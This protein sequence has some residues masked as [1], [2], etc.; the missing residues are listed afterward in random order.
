MQNIFKKDILF[1]HYGINVHDPNFIASLSPG[2]KE[3]I[4]G[5]AISTSNFGINKHISEERIKASVEFMKYVGLKEVQ[6][7]FLIKDHIMGTNMELYKDKNDEVCQFVPCEFIDKIDSL[8]FYDNDKRFFGSTEYLKNF[9]KYLLEYLFNDQPVDDVLQIL[10]DITKIYTFSI[11]PNDSIYGLIIFIVF[12]V[13]AIVITL[14]IVFVF[15]KKLEYRFKFLSKNFWIITTIGSLILLSAVLTLYGEVSNGKCHL[16]TFLINVGFI[17]S[18]CPSLHNLIA[19]FPKKNEISLKF[20]IN[21]Y[22]TLVVIMLITVCLNEV[23]SVA[24]FTIHEVNADI[25]P[26]SNTN[27][28]TSKHFNKCVMKNTFGKIMYY[29]IQIF[30]F[31]MI[32]ILLTLIFMEWNLKQ[33]ALDVKYLATALF[34]DILSLISLIIFS[35]T[36]IKNYIL[37]NVVLA[38]NIMFFAISNHIFIYLVRVLPIFRPDEEYEDSRKILGKIPISNHSK[39]KKY[40]GTNSSLNNKGLSS[41]NNKSSMAYYSN[42]ANSHYSNTGTSFYNNN[43]ATLSSSS[44]GNSCGSN[45]GTAASQKISYSST[46]K[47]SMPSSY[48]TINVDQSKSSKS[49]N[50]SLVTGST[51]MGGIVRK[52]M[53]YHNQTDIH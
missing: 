6:K 20:R 19:N 25:K 22:I 28:N 51:G 8:A 18:I 49:D 27:S 10:E 5:T 46:Y 53:D 36:E 2:W 16:R 4:S 12:L 32:L 52:I 48:S 17:L 34:M 39:P 47:Y 7:K 44:L 43:E 14:S 45:K 24:S 30:N 11:K 37:Y 9:Q 41:F 23:F 26:D 50:Y 1:L 33:T 15:I 21:K 3:G 13:L 42:L 40:P 29:I 31:F 35:V 38:V